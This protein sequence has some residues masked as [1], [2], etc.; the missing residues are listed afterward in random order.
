MIKEGTKKKLETFLQE[1]VCVTMNKTFNGKT[2]IQD[3]IDLAF[4]LNVNVTMKEE[5]GNIDCY[6]N[7]SGAPTQI[8][9]LSQLMV[10]IYTW[11]IPQTFLEFEDDLRNG[12]FIS[13]DPDGADKNQEIRDLY[14]VL[15]TLEN[16]ELT[17][18][19]VFFDR[20]QHKNYKKESNQWNT[21]RMSYSEL[22]WIY[23]IYYAIKSCSK[24]KTDEINRFESLHNIWAAHK[25]IR[26]SMCD[27]WEELTYQEMKNRVG[28]FNKCLEIVGG[29]LGV[30]LQQPF[31]KRLYDIYVHKEGICDMDIIYEIT[32]EK[33][34]E[35]IRDHK[36][37]TQK[38]DERIREKAGAKLESKVTYTFCGEEYIFK[39]RLESKD[40]DLYERKDGQIILLVEKETGAIIVTLTLADIE[41]RKLLVSHI[42]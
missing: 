23:N 3:F 32:L 9:S 17:P 38:H 11:Q 7:C 6:F 29:Y 22:V 31:T 20:I 12:Y 14:Q 13:I 5:N 35:L 30:D 42:Q 28:R 36:R 4:S 18:S 26:F 21:I 24:I 27:N 1:G 40:L 15:D 2:A 33:M 37:R 34:E 10:V 41:G 25:F 8:L 19:Y 39:G 16:A